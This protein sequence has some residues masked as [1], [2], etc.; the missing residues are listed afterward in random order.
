MLSLFQ[1]RRSDPGP[2]SPED[3]LN[4]DWQARF[5]AHLAHCDQC[6]PIDEPCDVGNR[7]LDAWKAAKQA[8][9]AG[10]E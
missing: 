3:R 5:R 6:D 9:R 4:A 1:M 2:V 10:G 8:L 7:I